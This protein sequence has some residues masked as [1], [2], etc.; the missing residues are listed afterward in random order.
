MVIIHSAATA[1]HDHSDCGCQLSMGVGSLHPARDT[2][3]TTIRTREYSGK[4]QTGTFDKTVRPNSSNS[5]Q[6]II[7]VINKHVTEN[8]CLPGGSAVAGP[9]DFLAH[10]FLARLCSRGRWCA[11]RWRAD[12]ARIAGHDI[13]K[14]FKGLKR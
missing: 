10:G 13:L 2:V 9:L 7:C 1:C 8:E 11:A 6:T 12:V 5:R 3:S 14:V 4:T